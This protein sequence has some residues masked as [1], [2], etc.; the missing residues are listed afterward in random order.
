MSRIP[1]EEWTS[2]LVSLGD[3]DYDGTVFAR[4]CVEAIAAVAHD[5]EV[6][7]G[8]EIE[9]HQAALGLAAVG[10]PNAQRVAE[11]ALETRAI[12]FGRWTA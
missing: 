9:L 8:M 1:P 6:A 3:R 5:D 2:L 12:E 4:K 7:H 11:I 10:H